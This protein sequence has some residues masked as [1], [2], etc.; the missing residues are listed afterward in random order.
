MTPAVRMRVRAFGK[1]IKH[2]AGDHWSLHH[3]V[4][5]DE[6]GHKKL[7]AFL[8]IK[9]PRSYVILSTPIRLLTILYNRWHLVH[10]QKIDITL[11]D[12]AM[13]FILDF[14]SYSILRQILNTSLNMEYTSGFLYPFSKQAIYVIWWIIY[15]LSGSLSIP[16]INISYLRFQD[17]FEQSIF[18]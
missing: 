7:T 1:A 16:L 11:G 8:Q 10:D 4:T 17:P 12:V 18:W 2:L 5:A 14:L 3:Y 15:S 6:H 9:S 13:D